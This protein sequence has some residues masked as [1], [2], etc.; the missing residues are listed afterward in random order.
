MKKNFGRNAAIAAGTALALTLGAAGVAVAAIS[1]PGEI[2]ACV[3]DKTGATRILSGLGCAQGEHQITWNVRGPAGPVGPTGPAGS[4]GPVGPAG[5]VGPAGPEGPVGPTG[6][7]GAKGEKGEKGDP[8]VSY[9]ET[10]LTEPASAIYRAGQE[11]VDVAKLAPI[12]PASYVIHGDVTFTQMNGSDVGGTDQRYTVRCDIYTQVPDN[13]RLVGGQYAT[14]GPGGH[15]ALSFQVAT[16]TQVSG[17]V[18]LR[19]YTL[20]G[21]GVDVYFRNIR[22]MATSVPKITVS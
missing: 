11:A 9:G 15:G 19:C 17:S 5:R 4:T 21:A 12:A 14:F 8:G 6:P 3:D 18:T 7:A 1:L 16:T 2:N 22:L 20:T 10:F 13:R